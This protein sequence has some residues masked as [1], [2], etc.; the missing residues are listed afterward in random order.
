MVSGQ[1]I[2]SY[3][4]DDEL[5][6]VYNFLI[7]ELVDVFTD[8]V[9]LCVDGDRG[10]VAQVSYQKSLAVDEDS[11]QSLGFLLELLNLLLNVEELLLKVLRE[12]LLLIGSFRDVH[13]KLLER[14]E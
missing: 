12:A 1:R 3:I 2:G 4:L 14:I 9:L 7:D 8:P 13:H 5:I 11:V 6:C 10:L